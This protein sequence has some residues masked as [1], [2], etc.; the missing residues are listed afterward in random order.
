MKAI[1]FEENDINM[2]LLMLNQIQTTGVEQAKLVVA[3]Y[4]LLQKG[5]SEGGETDGSSEHC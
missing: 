3:I 1:T 5:I 2:A 4:N